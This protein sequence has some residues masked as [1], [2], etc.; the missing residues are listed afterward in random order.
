M[1]D[2]KRSVRGTGN[3]VVQ[4]ANRITEK[5]LLEN[6]CKKANNGSLASHL[7]SNMCY[8]LVNGQ[9]AK[10]HEVREGRVLCEI[11]I[12]DRTVFSDA[13]RLSHNR[14]L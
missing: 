3:P 2:I 11:F 9:F 6:H 4:M 14:P 5:F 1:S 8:R 13:L 12:G 10:V 7:K